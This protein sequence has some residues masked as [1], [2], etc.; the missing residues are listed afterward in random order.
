MR[1]KSFI[2]NRFEECG[3]RLIDSLNVSGVSSIDSLILELKTLKPAG[4][5]SMPF[6]EYKEMKDVAI[7]LRAVVKDFL[8]ANKEFIVENKKFVQQYERFCSELETFIDL[9]SSITIERYLVH[10]IYHYAYD[11]LLFLALL[12]ER[13]STLQRITDLHMKIMEKPYD[14]VVLEE[15]LLENRKFADSFVE[16]SKKD[17]TAKEFGSPPKKDPTREFV[18][19]LNELEVVVLLREK[20]A[21]T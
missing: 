11:K 16:V 4:S 6:G 12:G 21:D 10:K 9:S 8:H 14:G 2:V 3:V 1:T 17:L 20:S 19:I 7:Q 18:A 5:V 15:Y 13:L